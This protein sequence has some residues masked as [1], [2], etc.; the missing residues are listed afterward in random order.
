MEPNNQGRILSKGSSTN[1]VGMIR[2]A[3]ARQGAK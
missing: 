1:V 2:R 3:G